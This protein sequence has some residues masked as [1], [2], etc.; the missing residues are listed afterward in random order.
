MFLDKEER[1]RQ[2]RQKALE[3]IAIIFS[4]ASLV[5]SIIALLFCL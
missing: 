4:T 3:I 5:F 2:R 1:A